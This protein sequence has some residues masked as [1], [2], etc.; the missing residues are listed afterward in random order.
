MEGDYSVAVFLEMLSLWHRENFSETTS[1]MILIFKSFIF[2]RAQKMKRECG[3]AI[4]LENN[5]TFCTD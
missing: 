1:S 5:I 2:L 3:F 4:F